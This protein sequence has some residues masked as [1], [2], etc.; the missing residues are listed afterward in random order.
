M[1]EING[2]YKH[3]KYKN[4]LLKTLHVMPNIKDFYNTRQLAGRTHYIDPYVTHMDQKLSTFITNIDSHTDDIS[5]LSCQVF[6]WAL[7]NA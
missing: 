5:M 2:A 6:L 3:D 7:K 4:I 1:V